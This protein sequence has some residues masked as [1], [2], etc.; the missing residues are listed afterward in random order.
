MTISVWRIAR[1][2]LD[3]ASD[4]LSGTGACVRGG[5]W[6]PKGTAVVYAATNVSLACLESATHSHVASAPMNCYLVRIDIPLPIWNQARCL[7]TVTAPVGWDAV[8]EAL[9]SVE[10]GQGWL[11][12]PDGPAILCVPSVIVPEEL[13]ILINPEHPDA[14]RITSFKIRKWI[15]DARIWGQHATK[16]DLPTP[17]NLVIEANVNLWMRN[18]PRADPIEQGYSQTA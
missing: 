17:R 10:F 14:R 3:Y 6:N 16:A 11:G 5:R 8:P 12:D 7:T 9:A 15:Y 13:N 4:G 2:T 1:E 18:R